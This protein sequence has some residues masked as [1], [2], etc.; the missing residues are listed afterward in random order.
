MLF[1][2]P[3]AWGRMKPFVVSHLGGPELSLDG[4]GRDGEAGHIAEII[5]QQVP[6]VHPVLHQ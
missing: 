4:P 1:L 3:I 6:C 2:I 5:Q